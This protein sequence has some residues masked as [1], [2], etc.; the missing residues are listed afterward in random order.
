MVVYTGDRVVSPYDNILP[1]DL[2]GNG[3]WVEGY[4]IAGRSYYF[5]CYNLSESQFVK[6]KRIIDERGFFVKCKSFFRRF[7]FMFVR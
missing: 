2:E 4:K 7:I 5:V 3:S 1:S 6:F